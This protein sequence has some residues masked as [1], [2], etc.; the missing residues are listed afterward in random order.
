M[1]TEH[2]RDVEILVNVC[3]YACVIIVCSLIAIILCILPKPIFYLLV[4]S[5]VLGFIVGYI[6]IF[7]RNWHGW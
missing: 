4:I 1:N 7:I 5:M 3:L 6:D 2:E